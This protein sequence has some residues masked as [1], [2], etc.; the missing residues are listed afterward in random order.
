MPKGKPYGGGRPPRKPVKK[1]SK[2][3]PYK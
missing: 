1:P 2:P 3:K